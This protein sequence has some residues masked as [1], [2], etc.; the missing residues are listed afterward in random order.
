MAMRPVPE[1]Y[2]VTQSF[3]GTFSTRYSGGSSHG[4]IDFATPT[5]TPVV[6]PINGTV[7][8]SDWAWHLPADSWE[9]RW[10]QLRP[11]VGDTGTGGG[12]MTVIRSD[13]GYH[14]ILAHLSDNNAAPKGTRVRMGDVVGK[15]GNTGSSTGPHLHMAL[16]PPNPNWGNGTY[17]SIDPAPYLVT[18]YRTNTVASWTGSAT[19]GT[20]TAAKTTTPKL[21]PVTGPK[22]WID[23]S[24]HQPT[25][26][27]TRV[28]ADAVS[29]KASEGVGWRDPDMAAHVKA[30]RA[31]G[32][33][34]SLYHFARATK[35]DSDSEAKWFLSVVKP[36]L[37]DPLLDHLVLD[38]E[39]PELETWEGRKAWI[40][41]FLVY[42]ARHAPGERRAIYTRAGFLAGTGWSGFT[43]GHTVW[44]ADYGT[45]KQVNGYKTSTKGAPSVP[46]WHVGAWQYTQ[47]GRLPGYAGDLDLNLT[48]PAAAGMQLWKA[49]KTPKTPKKDEFDMAT[50]KE[51]DKIV[52][53]HTRGTWF[54]A[55]SPN[56]ELGKKFRK[57]VQ[58]TVKSTK[59]PG[60]GEAKGDQTLEDFIKY[61][62][63]ERATT[64]QFQSDAGKAL[65][66]LNTRLTALEKGATSGD[67]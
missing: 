14:W 5:G 45:D 6:A 38:F 35:N 2:G 42:L 8:H 64:K 16:I 62:R 12:I 41:D 53:K 28:K 36:Y 34:Y 55:L 57:W 25:D 51:L 20:G 65:A 63:H 3:A 10:Y 15:T 58:D 54:D 23:V 49:T 50:L 60:F 22:T 48:L 32:I 39:E 30:A 13:A 47:R 7:V 29:I 59:F 66:D 56:T 26:V 31:K 40:N 43:R 27:I 21:V 46:G 44:L 37:K 19:T 18:A 24:N 61:D 33:R 52:E 1:M 4:A 67:Q 17:G 11:A 9:A